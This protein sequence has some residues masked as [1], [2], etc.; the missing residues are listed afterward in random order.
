MTNFKTLAA[1][2]TAGALIAKPALADPR[3]FI[4]KLPVCSQ[5]HQTDPCI[6]H[7]ATGAHFVSSSKGY[8]VNCGPY[9]CEAM[10]YYYLKT[11]HIPDPIASTCGNGLTADDVTCQ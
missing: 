11:K 3:S 5:A 7:A 2:L 1:A 6:K 9:N 4:D 8:S 10:A